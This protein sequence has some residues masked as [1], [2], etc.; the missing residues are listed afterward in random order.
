MNAKQIARQQARRYFKAPRDR[1]IFLRQMKQEANFTDATSGAGAQ[2]PAQIMPQTA[3]GWGV[4]NVHDPTE[5]YGAAAKHMADYLKQTHGSWAKALQMYNLGH[6]SSNPPAETRNYV[7]KILGG[8]DVKAGATSDAPPQVGRSRTPLSLDLGMKSTFDEAGF[9]A[10]RKA[11]IA[12]RLIARHRGTDNILFKSGLLSTTSPSR[13]DFTGQQL[14]SKIVGGKPIA[15]AS[16]GGDTGGGGGGLGLDTAVAFSKHK[17][18]YLWGGGH[19]KIAKPSERVD[20]SGY[21]SAIVGLKTPQVSGWF[22]RNWGKPGV[23]KQR[24]V[25][26]SDKHVFISIRDP[27]S[28]KLRW[29]GTSRSNPGGGP[30]E[31]PAPSKSYLAGFT[32]RHG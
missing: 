13:E 1:R 3:K 18:A 19:G 31:I 10:A 26:A 9:E 30:G 22:A 7:S 16:A 6:V 12:G 17:T 14:T 5:A 23:G 24:T 11:S 4:K 8:M 25:W 20:C 27:R 29:F 21:V 32:P 15:G 2:G 28:G